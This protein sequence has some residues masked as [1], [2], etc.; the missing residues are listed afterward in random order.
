MNRE[1]VLRERRSVNPQIVR[2]AKHQQLQSTPMVGYYWNGNKNYPVGYFHSG[3]FEFIDLKSC[4]VIK[5]Y[6]DAEIEGEVYI[7]RAKFFGVSIYDSTKYR[8]DFRVF[9]Y[10][11]DFPILP[12]VYVD[13][14]WECIPEYRE[15]K[16]GEGYASY[17]EN[18]RMY[19]Y[20]MFKIVHYELF[21]KEYPDGCKYGW[22]Y[23][24]GYPEY[25]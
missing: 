15:F 17:I 18:Q 23:D 22:H 25:R 13:G 4:K 3:Y 1:V 5:V 10:F 19:S 20:T 14:C 24:K 11:K 6:T 9:R 2:T 7:L 8:E 12:E 21:G 16:M